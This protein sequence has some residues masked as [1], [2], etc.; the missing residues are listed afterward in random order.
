MLASGMISGRGVHFFASPTP[1]PLAGVGARA[2]CTGIR[3][4]LDDEHSRA[5][6][7]P[8]RGRL[9][10]ENAH[11][12][13]RKTLVG[14]LLLLGRGETRDGRVVPLAVHTRFDKS[15]NVFRA[16][17]HLH[18]SVAAP[19]ISGEVPPVELELSNGATRHR[20]LT[21]EVAQDAIRS[22]PLTEWLGRALL[23]IRAADSR[24]PGTAADLTVR[25]GVGPFSRALLRARV[26]AEGG[27]SLRDLL[28]SGAWELELTALASFRSLADHLARAM[29]L[30]GLDAC[31]LT[32]AIAARGL[33]KGEQL[34]FAYQSGRGEVRLAGRSAEVPDPLAIARDYLEYDFLG[35][36]L[37]EELARQLAGPR[38]AARGP[39]PILL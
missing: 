33:A 32:A 2:A 6:W 35:A 38:A 3:L 29:F 5:T 31:P 9:T 15:G 13:A 37:A 26:R 20:V 17:P 27:T 28:A 24:E 21:P 10:V 4:A 8:A 34:S 16:R 25:V 1:T 14:D 30:L 23:S 11:A 36:V 12:Y 22:P 7:D 18:P 39:V 19:L